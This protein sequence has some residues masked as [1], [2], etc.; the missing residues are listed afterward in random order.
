MNQY[1]H[2]NIIIITLIVKL[3]TYNVMFVWKLIYICTSFDIY[4]GDK[5]KTQ[6]RNRIQHM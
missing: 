5:I 2:I 4:I 1:L 3:D 6:D